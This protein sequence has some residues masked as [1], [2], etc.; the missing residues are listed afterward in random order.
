MMTFWALL[1]Y[2]SSLLLLYKVSGSVAEASGSWPWPLVVSVSAFFFWLLARLWSKR[3]E[4]WPPSASAVIGFGLLINFSTLI[5]LPGY[6]DLPLKSSAGA[7]AAKLAGLRGELS[8]RLRETGVAP[9]DLSW[10]K[11]KTPEL[12][13]ARSGHPKSWEIRISSFTDIQDSGRWLYVA[14]SAGPEV[15]IDCT[16]SDVKGKAWSAY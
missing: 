10:Q 11:K 8:V 13:L 14:D 6:S 4:P 12:W 9:A 16:H 1:Y 7:Q 3:A 2:L 15:L 5:S